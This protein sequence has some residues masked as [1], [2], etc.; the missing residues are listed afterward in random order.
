MDQKPHAGDGSLLLSLCKAEA[1]MKCP[2]H[3]LLLGH[4]P[5]S[6][7]WCVQATPAFFPKSPM[8]CGWHRSSWT[9]ISKSLLQTQPTNTSVSPQITAVLFPLRTQSSSV[10]MICFLGLISVELFWKWGFNNE[11]EPKIQSNVSHSLSYPAKWVKLYEPY[12]KRIT[13]TTWAS[14]HPTSVSVRNL[15]PLTS[16]STSAL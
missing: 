7:S 6:P 11:H 9:P 2:Q 5:T 1:L 14:P 12:Q 15:F 8:D 3:T 16:I 10:S 13:S 4:G